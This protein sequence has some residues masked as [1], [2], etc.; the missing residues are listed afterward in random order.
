VEAAVQKKK[1]TPNQ[2]QWECIQSLSGPIM[3]LA[4][5]GTGK[6][7][8]IIQ[9]IKYMLEQG[10]LPETIL[11]LTFSEAAAGEMKIRLVKEVGTIASSVEISTYHAFC[12]NIISQFPVKFELVE[13]FNIIDDLTKYS[14]MKE[15][16]EE[17]KP[18]ALLARDYDPYYYIKPLL[19]AVDEIKLNR[20]NK[21]KYFA[22]LESGK[23]WGEQLK[24]L[25]ADKL[26]QIEKAKLGKRN[27]LKTVEKEILKIEENIEK[28]KEAWDI[29]E[30]YIKKM[31]E[32]NLIDF[33]DMINFVLNTFE[34]DPAFAQSIRSKYKYL[35][36]DEYQDTNKSQNELIFAL[37]GDD[38]NA[39]ILVVGDDDQVIYQFQGAQ[40][41]NL[42]K[43]LNTYKNAK[44]ICLE[45]NN[46]S[47]Q[48]V[49]DLSREILQQTPARLE[50]NQ[51]FLKYGIN[52]TLVAKNPDI[53][54]KERITEL[55]SFADSVQEI[56]FIVDKIQQVVK[57]NPELPLSEISIL[58][59]TNGELE[60][61]AD[62]LKNKGIPFQTN[63]KKDIF[64]LK[65][66][67]LIY[68]YLKAL[69][70]H[71]L[72]SAGL[73]GMLNHPPF[74]FHI[75]DYT[76]LIK[77]CKTVV[78]TEN[79]DRTEHKNFISVLKD[80]VETRN[81]SDRERIVKF[82]TTFDEIKTLQAKEN[83]YNIIIHVLN[84]T[85]ILKYYSENPED[86]FENIASIKKITDEGRTFQRKNP[87]A[88]LGEFLAYLDTSLKQG[89]P[90]SI[91]DSNIVKNAVQLV[92]AHKSKGREFSYVF[93]YNLTSKNWEKSPSRDKLKIP[94]EKA[95]FS[96]DPDVAKDAE[97][98]RLLFVA[99]TRAKYALYMTHSILK[100]GKNLELSKFISHL[101]DNQSIISKNLYE[102]KPDELAQEYINQFILPE[103]Y[104][105]NSYLEELKERAKKHVMSA[106]SLNDYNACPRK[107]LY[108]HIYRIPSFEYTSP[109]LAFGTAV[110]EGF[111]KFTKVA[112]ETREYP[113]KQDL[114]GY[115]MNCLDEQPFESPEE[116]QNYIIRGE[117]V[118]NAYFD[119]FISI[120][121]DKVVSAEMDLRNIPLKDDLLIKGKIDRIE[122][123][124]EGIAVIDF[125]TG[126]TKT[127]NSIETGKH[128]D[129]MDQLRFY[130]LLYEL[131][132]PGQK[133]L[134]GL[135]IFVEEPQ[136]HEFA[137]LEDDKELIADKIV[138]TFEKIHKLEFDACDMHKQ[139]GDGC[140]FC[141]YKL[142]CRVNAV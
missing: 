5:P 91:E 31:Q 44:V 87:S 80:E 38:E 14:L 1:I 89:I 93:L 140:K 52:K 4:G 72:Y 40:T 16:I 92:T 128:S 35:L 82:L 10:I 97:V 131:K 105:C 39:N 34:S 57:E 132:H 83:I 116:R 138:S 142:L 3:V 66:S 50:D 9:R 90:L 95:N 106:T 18:K 102:L 133:V 104:T 62:I 113:H 141:N 129:Y 108:A 21:E 46:R 134:K 119:R 43:F 29:I 20:V 99:I 130:K 86:L 12:N 69:D 37:A 7:F 73:F 11:C 24:E 88:G 135:L 78:Q 33:N 56:N 76:Y 58:A 77:N 96:D 32:N 107:F 101:A 64:S 68:L 25:N 60:N 55:H 48:T 125:K 123:T 137:L 139:S 100:D 65:P 49:L 111:E 26:E 22:V 118:L 17:Y 84:K 19:S 27:R 45:E 136:T 94:V 112:L 126:S 8:T 41:D 98:G 110:H 122:K 121:I 47:T 124:E 117:N 15:I 85:G 13:H 51:D 75:D 63:K 59:R 114:V 74:S 53:I 28:A 2:K 61:F 54:E 109:A 71:Q 6:T 103:I 79:G 115:F 120:P 70:N 36:V 67:L 81:W 30:I 23:D 42:E 127:R